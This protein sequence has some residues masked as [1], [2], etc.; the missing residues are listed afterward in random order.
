MIRTIVA[1]LT[2]A[3]LLGG[4][5]GVLRST[6]DVEE[7][8]APIATSGEMGEQVDTTAFQLRV[9]R[10]QLGRSVR[11]ED[12]FGFLGE[13]R[14]TAGIWVVV[15]ATVAAT[16]EETLVRGARLRTAD[17]MEYLA[18]S[19]IGT[20][21]KVPLQ[22]GIPAYGPILFELP[23]DRL[24]GATLHVTVHSPIEG[25]YLGPAADVDLRL[26][27]PYT[28]KLIEQAPPTLVVGPV[29]EL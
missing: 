14:T 21:D 5:L 8:Y 18:S 22:P 11:L 12:A 20:L 7:K 15:W 1:V 23:P 10:L 26:S 16:T 27:A 13:P 25:D 24:T 3:L 28:K 29:R 2:G 6:P 17:G 19:L 9:D 4:I